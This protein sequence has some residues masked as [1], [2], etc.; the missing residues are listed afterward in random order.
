MDSY[1]GNRHFPGLD[2]EMHDFMGDRWIS[3]RSPRFE[4]ARRVFNGAIDRRP[5][6]IA[7]CSS[8]EDVL[9]TLAASESHDYKLT[10]RSSGHN[11]AGR[12]VADNS[13]VL[14]VSHMNSVA[15][16]PQT[17]RAMTGPGATWGVFDRATQRYGLAT[18]GGTVASTGLAGL[19][20][21]GG[22]GWLLPSYGLTCDSLISATV[23]ATDG[24]VI[25]AS[26]N[27][28]PEIMRAL[29]GGGFGL[30]IVVALDFELHHVPGIIGGA[31]TFKISDAASVLRSFAE[32][33]DGLD[34]SVMV[35]PALL[36][37]D[38][39]PVLEMDV[40]INGHAAAVDRFL[41]CLPS[42]C[43]P[44]SDTLGARAYCD[45][46]SM[47]DNPF[48]RGLHAYWKS[49]F[50]DALSDDV[51]AVLIDS[52][53]R[54]PTPD[55]LIMIEHYHGK[56]QFPDRPSA[57]PY[58]EDELNVLLVANWDGQ[59]AD[60]NLGDTCELWA[61]ATLEALPS[62]CDRAYANYLAVDDF[63][64]QSSDAS[65]DAVRHILDP[66]TRLAGW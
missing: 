5:R 60:P 22:V 33:L 65:V 38:G 55:S 34:N 2:S 46:Q 61:R 43:E 24:R 8:T 6:G 3:P 23:V 47:L 56:Y 9:R 30:G 28:H 62:R 18:T 12:A 45:L 57:F 42:R 26:D 20:L 31:I 51:I 64:L 50:L 66:G 1:T 49:N 53:H 48:R 44:V 13:V 17:S 25:E 58:R 59:S 39:I 21:G 35:S 7:L 63:M 29:R 19:T 40:A 32:H 37:V 41:R 27:A 11:V 4:D 36:T 16:T 15:V 54:A 14:D 10:I 52:I